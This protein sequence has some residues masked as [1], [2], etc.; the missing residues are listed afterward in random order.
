MRQFCR[1]MT[2]KELRKLERKVKGQRLIDLV[3]KAPPVMDRRQLGPKAVERM[4]AEVANFVTSREREEGWKDGDLVIVVVAS[5]DQQEM[6][7]AAVRFEDRLPNRAFCVLENPT[8]AWQGN[9]L[10]HEESLEIF[11]EGASVMLTNGFVCPPRRRNLVKMFGLG[12][13]PNVEVDEA[14]DLDVANRLAYKE[15][16]RR[17]EQFADKAT[18]TCGAS[19]REETPVE[20]W[21]SS[22]CP[23]QLSEALSF[24]M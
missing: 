13:P 17:W 4:L 2:A 12:L 20:L 22:T 5:N 15:V 19:K 8:V 3:P 1:H 16:L 11:P 14:A 6:F 21:I 18:L 10:V 7:D 23:S 24:N 9:F